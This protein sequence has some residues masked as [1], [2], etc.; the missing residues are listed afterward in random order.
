VFEFTDT[1]TF[2]LPV[3]IVA[4]KAYAKQGGINVEWTAENETNIAYYEVEKSTNG[5]AYSSIATLK[6][7]NTNKAFTYNNIDKAL[8][9]SANLYYRIKIVS[10]DGTVKYTPSV[11][12]STNSIGTIRVYPNPVTNHSFSLLLN[13]VEK[14]TYQLKLANS[15]GMGVHTQTINHQ[16]GSANERIVLQN[17]AKGAYYLQI[18]NAKGSVYTQTLLVE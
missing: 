8:V 15:L 4:V 7:N 2:P 6:A 1:T 12:I 16:G 10:K 9:G 11:A 18:D 3:G 17:L 14:G 5:V 13:N